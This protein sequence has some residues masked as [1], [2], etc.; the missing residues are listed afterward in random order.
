MTAHPL[1]TI[2][3][4]VYNVQNYLARCVS[5]VMSQPYRHLEIILVDDGSPDECPRM[6]D[7]YA[8]QDSRVK[9]VHKSNGGLASARNAGLD[10]MHGDYVYF[11]D[12]DDWIESDT[13]AVLL[14]RMERHDVDVAMGG[15]IVDV[16]DGTSHPYAFDQVLQTKVYRREEALH[17]FLYHEG[18]ASSAW[19]KL[20]RASLFEGEHRLRFPDGLN[21]E[22]Y[23][24]LAHLFNRMTNGLYVE[25]KPPL[26]HYCQRADSI[27]TTTEID[28]HT[29][30]KIVI[31]D[32]CTSYLEQAGYPD[33]HALNYFRMMGRYDVLYS[34]FSKNADLSMIRRY[35]KELRESAKPVYSDPRVSLAR[36]AKI[37][38]LSHMPRLYYRLQ[39]H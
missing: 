37:A 30:D 6:C 15:T 36:K 33:T 27:C 9:A 26:Y 13:V 2:I 12:S 17:G 19:G 3:V 28:A 31:A 7:E 21:S 8:R 20:Y 38:F 4:P 32:K 24:L 23:Y 5:S 25:L 39:R 29:F 16:D 1:I 22:D 11:V 14:E 34:L 10:A 18:L 35:A